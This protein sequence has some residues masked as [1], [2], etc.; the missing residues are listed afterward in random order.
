MA[1]KLNESALEMQMMLDKQLVI[2]CRFWIEGVAMPSVG[3]P[4]IIGKSFIKGGFEIISGY[5]R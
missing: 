4:G 2:S 5:C 1:T 3:V